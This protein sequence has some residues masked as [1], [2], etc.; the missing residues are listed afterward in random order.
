VTPRAL[1]QPVNF[2][3]IAGSAQLISPSEISSPKLITLN[4]FFWASES[5]ATYRFS[6]SGLWQC[7][8]FEPST[9]A[10]A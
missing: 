8:W 3:C 5:P 7:P 1:S 10:C 6:S 4:A 2:A 9:A